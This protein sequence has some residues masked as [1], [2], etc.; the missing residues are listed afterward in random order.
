MH[1]CMCFYYIIQ[2]RNKKGVVYTFATGNDGEYSDSCA[3]NGYV[4]SIYTIAVGSANQNGEQAVYD[5]QCAAKMVV[6]FALNHDTFP[7]A[8]D[9]WKAFK[10]IVSVANK[11]LRIIVLCSSHL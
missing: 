4:S 6:T 11:Y 2:G 9:D 7:S 3:A 1:A 10:Q 8:S 5:E